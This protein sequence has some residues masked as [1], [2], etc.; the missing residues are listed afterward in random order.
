[1]IRVIL[2]DDHPYLRTGVAAVLNSADIQI[3]AAVGDGDAALAAIANENPD[4]ALLDV[5][6][7]IRDGISTLE[8]MRA[9]GDRR[10]VILLTA[11]ID[12]SRLLAAMKAEVNGIVFKQGAEQRLIEAVHTVHQGRRAIEADLLERTI[13]LS[14]APSAIGPLRLLAPKE[15]QIAD[16]VSRGLRNREIAAAMH[17]TEGSIKIYLHN[18]YTKLNI[19]NRTE[20]AS[21]VLGDSTAHT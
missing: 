8:A 20:L 16:A 13:S 6:M 10:P 3:V 18:I 15:R 5:N 1:M 19:D 2:A 9:A 21:L 12:D 17:M 4:I 11:E 14:L 7:P